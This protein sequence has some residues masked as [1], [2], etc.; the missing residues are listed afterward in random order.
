VILNKWTKIRR[1]KKKKIIHIIKVSFDSVRY[2]TLTN[3]LNRTTAQW[4]TYS[5]YFACVLKSN[6]KCK[7]NAIYASIM[8]VGGLT[9]TNCMVG[10][11]VQVKNKRLTASILTE[12]LSK[13][14]QF[15]KQEWLKRMVNFINVEIA[16]VIS[17]MCNQ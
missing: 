6:G 7:L 9:M 13:S 1:K 3:P 2:L 5:S 10:S 12:N 17:F 14:L 11:L 4:E 16:I 8:E 15:T